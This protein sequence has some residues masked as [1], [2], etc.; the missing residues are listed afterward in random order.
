MPYGT[1]CDITETNGA[2]AGYDLKLAQAHNV[3]V[4]AP[5]VNVEVKNAYNKQPFSQFAITKNVEGAEAA[6]NKT[7]EFDLTCGDE[8][9]TKPSP[10]KRNSNPTPSAR[11]RRKPNPQK[12][13]DT[14]TPFTR[15]KHRRSPLV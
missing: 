8:K 1:T 12:F 9:I 2:V 3:P 14:A 4:N 13:R 11:Q 10:T 7:Y 5:K 6:K 15:R